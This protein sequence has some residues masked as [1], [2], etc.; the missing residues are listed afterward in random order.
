MPHCKTVSKTRCNRFEPAPIFIGDWL[1]LV[2]FFPQ[3]KEQR[4]VIHA[5]SPSLNLKAPAERYASTIVFPK[6]INE[7]SISL[8]CWMPK[9]M[10]M[11]VRQSRKPNDMCARAVANP[12]HNIQM[13]LNTSEKQPTSPPVLTAFNPNGRNTNSPSLKHCNPNGIPTTVR[14]RINPPIK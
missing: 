9:G 6:G 12:P 7:V 3:K 1:F 10:P 14:Q 4:F 5:S 13:M 8:K 11:M 2:L